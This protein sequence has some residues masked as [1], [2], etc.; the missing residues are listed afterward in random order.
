[1]I[2]SFLFAVLFQNVPEKNLERGFLL[3]E[4]NDF[5]MNPAKDM[6]VNGGGLILL[7][8]RSQRIVKIEVSDK[9]TARGAEITHR[10]DGPGELSTPF[11][12]SA[13][14]GSGFAVYD[15]RGISLFDDNLSS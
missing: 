13:Y 10:G 3:V 6:I 2:L 5:Y 7:E 12:M 11:F 15:M 8:K 9:G 14:A 1:M 4:A